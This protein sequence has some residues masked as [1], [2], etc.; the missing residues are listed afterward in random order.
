MPLTSKISIENPD[1]SQFF[2][3]SIEIIKKP[4][5]LIP[6]CK[7]QSVTGNVLSGHVPEPIIIGIKKS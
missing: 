1:R 3:I 5:F 4:K 2:K 7:N 6:N